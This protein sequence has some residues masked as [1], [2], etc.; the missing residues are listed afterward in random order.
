MQ[1][2]TLDT[3]VDG[4]F[5][6]DDQFLNKNVCAALNAILYPPTCFL[7]RST[8]QATNTSPTWTVVSWDNVITDTEDPA[9]PIWVAGT[10]TRLNC[11]T[12]GWYEC[13]ANV[14]IVSTA[15]N[16]SCTVAF[17]KNGDSNQ[18]YGADS[19][20]TTGTGWA[21]SCF[22]TLIPLTATSDYLEVLF[23]HTYTSSPP[24]MCLKWGAPKV[25]IKKV[26]GI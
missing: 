11:R 2:V 1:D 12:V 22:T 8:T 26:R 18:I 6:I 5:Q 23:K 10:P 14:G 20:P 21:M 9:L 15:S 25:M 13:T 17:Q 7:Y 4:T 16:N 3:P 19:S 24:A